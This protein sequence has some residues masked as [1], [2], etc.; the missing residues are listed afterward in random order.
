MEPY[1]SKGYVWIRKG[2][3]NELVRQMDLWPSLVRDDVID[4]WAMSRHVL[5]KYVPDA[6]EIT[7]RKAEEGLEKDPYAM[8][9]LDQKT[10][11]E[12]TLGWNE[13]HG[14]TDP[15]KVNHGNI[16]KGTWAGRNTRP[17]SPEKKPVLK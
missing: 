4:S 16:S 8:T 9:F 11:K 5:M 12:V 17:P 6:K 15:S 13:Y 7:K 10:G 14:I 3:C 1:V 2:F